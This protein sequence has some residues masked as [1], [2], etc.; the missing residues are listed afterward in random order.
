MSGVIFQEE[1]LLLALHFTDWHVTHWAAV[2][3]GAVASL[4]GFRGRAARRGLGLTDQVREPRRR[5]RWSSG[6]GLGLIRMGF[7]GLCGG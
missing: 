3:P 2:D 6:S 4:G 7:S 5:G 1:G